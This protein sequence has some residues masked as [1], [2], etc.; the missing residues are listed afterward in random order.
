MPAYTC[1]PVAAW[2]TRLRLR[3][4]VDNTSSTVR[5]AILVFTVF[6]ASVFAGCTDGPSEP[7]PPATAVRGIMPGVV[8]PAGE[9]VS[10]I[11]T[12]DQGWSDEVAAEFYGTTQGSEIIPLD[13]FLHLERADGTGKISDADFITQLGY[14]PRVPTADNERGLPV[15]FTESGTD[16]NPQLGLTCAACHTTQIVHGDISYLVDGAPSLGD[17]AALNRAIAAAIEGTIEDPERFER[18]LTALPSGDPPAVKRSKLQTLLPAELER[19]KAFN[20]RNLPKPGAEAPR[21]GYGR[22]DAFGA[23]FNEVAGRFLGV[24]ENVVPPTAPVSYPFLWD[25]PQHDFVQWDGSAPNRPG[26][27]VFH[28]LRVGALARNTGEVLGVY[29]RYGNPD[30]PADVDYRSS[31][32]FKNLNALESQV[33]GLWSPEWPFDPKPANDGPKVLRGAAI[34]GDYC[35]DCHRPIGDRTSPARRVKAELSDTQTDPASAANTLLRTVRTGPLEGARRFRTS[36]GRFGDEAGAA[37]VL[38][39]VAVGVILNGFRDAPRDPLEELRFEPPTKEPW[40][41]RLFGGEITMMTV[42][43]DDRPR[44]TVPS[45]REWAKYK[46]RP[47]NGIW[48]TGPYLHNGSVPTLYD[49]LLPADDRPETFYVGRREFDVEK[50]GFKSHAPPDPDSSPLQEFDTSIKGNRNV[51]HE[52][53]TGLPKEAGG[54][55]LPELS[56]D[57]R[58]DLLEYL[59][60]L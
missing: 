59:K 19:R 51:G 14:I 39:H 38:A 34:F 31:V 42:S 37:D 5:R 16:E 43:G 54:D 55:G 18:L 60:T 53:G 23:I 46:A 56:V 13:W 27:A 30:D 25:T 3:R 2:F 1:S 17:F 52:Y 24:P 40:W 29:G 6:A 8:G 33:A 35:A 57:E 7:T 49:L 28:R 10:T 50:V 44:S 15:G 32:E 20:G 26:P 21:F 9:T 36:G 12:L 47:L 22:L 11:R 58:A 4:A 48:G 41:D 45:I